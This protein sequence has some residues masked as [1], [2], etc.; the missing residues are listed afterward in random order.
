VLTALIFTVLGS[1]AFKLSAWLRRHPRVGTGLNLG[2][3]L[4]FIA[5]GLSVL[6]LKQRT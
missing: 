4:T 6:A 2:A 5:A 3:G 1:F